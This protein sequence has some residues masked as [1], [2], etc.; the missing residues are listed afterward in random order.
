MNVVEGLQTIKALQEKF[1]NE[2]QIMPGGGV[3]SDN[4]YDILN[5]IKVNNIHCSASKK[6]QRCNDFKAFPAESLE[7]KFL[8]LMK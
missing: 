5:T 1:G 4:V 6:V 8:K 3:N 2:I 7:K